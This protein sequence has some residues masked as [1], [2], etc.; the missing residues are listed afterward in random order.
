MMK[1]KFTLSL[2]CL[3]LAFIGFSCVDGGYKH[4]IIYDAGVYDTILESPK[5][6][7]VTIEIN[8]EGSKMTI[9]WPVVL[10]A[11]GYEFTLY[12][13]DDPDNW[14]V[15]G[16]EKQIIDGCSITIDIEEDTKYEFYIKTLGNEQY[17]NQEAPTACKLKYSTLVPTYKVISV[18]DSKDL[19]AY[20]QSNP[21]PDIEKIREE[22]EA[23]TGEPYDGDEV[24]YE[25]EVNGKF[26]ISNNLNFGSAL[27]TLRGDKIKRPSIDIKKGFLNDGTGLKLKYVNFD[28]SNMTGD[29]FLAFNKN[30]SIVGEWK[31][32]FSPILMQACRIENLP[33]PL[34]HDGSKK[35]GVQTVVVKDCVISNNAPGQRFIYMQSGI[36]KDLT[37][38]NST[39][40]YKEKGSAYFIQY[41]NSRVTQVNE[42]ADKTNVGWL[43]GGL[44]INNCTI[45]QAAYSDQMANYAGLAQKGNYLNITRTIFVDCAE[46]A[47]RRF[48]GGGG[49]FTRTFGFNAYW[50]DGAFNEKELT[51][52]PKDDS[53]SHI[54]DNPNLS[55]PESGLFYPAQVFIDKESGDP[56]WWSKETENAWWL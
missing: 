35:F 18:E 47:I 53:G 55:A 22:I 10:G 42:G 25:L 4:D 52:N 6:E 45:W 30:V 9:T 48:G 40:F 54:T 46:E 39:I 34:I 5:K 1:K 8:P 27:V 26:E 23:E 44:R 36:I 20:F 50:R 12:N 21:V 28:C 51:T 13:A 38:E 16:D 33:K 14:V 41:N 49:N 24:V 17:R 11:G 7:D 56:R 2:L 3:T 29:A 37:L 15:I 31:P 19:Y 32:V 43:S